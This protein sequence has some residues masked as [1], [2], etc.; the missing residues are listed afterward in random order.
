MVPVLFIRFPDSVSAG[1]STCVAEDPGVRRQAAV[2][3][4]AVG[5]LHTAAVVEAERA[6]AAAVTRAAGLN[7]GCDLRPLLQVQSDAVHLQRANA[8]P[9]ALLPGRCASWKQKRSQKI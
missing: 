1:E 7:P 9:E 4:E 3:V 5:S 2:T 8:A 6:V